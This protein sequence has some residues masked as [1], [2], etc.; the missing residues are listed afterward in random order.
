MDVIYTLSTKQQHV[1]LKAC[2]W[3]LA[4]DENYDRSDYDLLYREKRAHCHGRWKMKFKT[5]KHQANNNNN[6][7]SYNTRQCVSKV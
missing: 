6:G 1:L 3:L 2:H 5:T 7:S 4:I